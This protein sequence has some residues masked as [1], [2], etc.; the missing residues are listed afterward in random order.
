MHANT[1]TGASETMKQSA[2]NSGTG[3][4][5]GKLADV[6]LAEKCSSAALSYDF[7]GQPNLILIFAQARNEVSSPWC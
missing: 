1:E 3:G 6:G 4:V 5:Q 7:S 2:W